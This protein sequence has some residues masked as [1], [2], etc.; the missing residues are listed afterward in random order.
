MIRDVLPLRIT[1]GSL[2]K[3]TAKV[4]FPNLC[5]DPLALTLQSL[6]L[7]FTLV[8]IPSTTSST[9]APTSL[10][11]STNLADSVTSAADEFLHSELDVYEEAALS[12][13]IQQS[14]IFTQNNPFVKEDDEI[15][16]S[17]PVD[18]GL[19]GDA[20]TTTTTVLTGLVERIL[21]RLEFS[22]RDIRIR[23]RIIVPDEK[24]GGVL[25]IRVRDVGYV[26]ESVEGEN[27]RVVRVKGVEVVMLP[28][29]KGAPRQGVSRSSSVSTSS[30]GE[31]E[32]EMEMSMA[33]ADLRESIMGMED[34]TVSGG[35]VY[36]SA[37]S[38][39]PMGSGESVRSA[40]PTG[41]IVGEEK[42]RTILSFGSEDIVLRMRRAKV[43]TNEVQ[44]SDTPT[45]DTL[46]SQSVNAPS[47]PPVKFE[48]SF[49]TIAAILLPHQIA[50]LLTAVQ[51]VSPNTTTPGANPDVVAASQPKIEASL[52]IKAIHLAVIYDMTA[53]T[54][55]NDIYTQAIAGFWAKPNSAA[56]PVG[57]IRLRLESLDTSYTTSG[58]SSSRSH[59]QRPQMDRA[60]SSV[61][62]TRRAS[63]VTRGPKPP[64]FRCTIL[65]MSIFE[66]LASSTTITQH[67]S[68]PGGSFPVVIFDHGLTKQ[69]DASSPTTDVVFPEY[70]LVDW[71]D[72]GLQRKATGPANE[73]AWKVRHKGRGVLKGG[74]ESQAE[75]E[76]P[77]FVMC[78]P[79][80]GNTGEL[81][82][83]VQS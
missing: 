57:H 63:F 78:K 7:D 54:N 48:M 27:V 34:S 49:G 56:I 82:K 76:K 52:M 19:M 26:D 43:S 10:S 13:S 18:N 46:S 6:Y 67:D 69:Y 59:T 32:G 75:V 31:G 64:V 44:A 36:E 21:A 72:S 22:V 53:D 3:V 60:A 83:C 40:T 29:P 80:L 79:M 45:S 8:S 9:N 77:V 39:G 41:H 35:S 73:K 66:Y 37:M 1:S 71:R 81:I 33:V 30:E 28:L 70:D 65:D 16:G 61:N 62:A 20:T 24:V 14:I 17:F 47:L 11:Q 51:L 50:T 74:V 23:I 5:S 2:A 42:E 38:E 15:P 4:P 12:S 55:I 68:P 58:S 25:E